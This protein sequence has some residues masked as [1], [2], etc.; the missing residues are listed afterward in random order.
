[1]VMKEERK[2]SIERAPKV[3][4]KAVMKMVDK[5]NKNTLRRNS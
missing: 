2:I 1:M 3:R 5:A 4:P